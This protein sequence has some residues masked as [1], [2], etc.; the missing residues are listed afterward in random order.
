MAASGC[1]VNSRGEGKA[2][3][4]GPSRRGP[5]Q[6]PRCRDVRIWRQFPGDG[7][8]GPGCAGRARLGGPADG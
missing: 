5:H 3:P 6:T 8:A 1:G 4:L 2:G 7:P